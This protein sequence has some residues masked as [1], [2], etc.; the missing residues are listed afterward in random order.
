MNTLAIVIACGKEEEVSAGVE[1]AFLTLGNRPVLAHS[2]RTF[3]D[4]STIDGIIVAVSKERVE[5][6]LQVIKRFGYTKVCGIV[7][8]GTNRLSSLRT[9]FSKL[10]S[11]ASYIIVHEASRPFITEQAVGECVKATKRYGCAI[12][13]HKLPDVV[14]VAAKGLKPDKTIERNSAWSAQTPQAFKADVFE[15]IIHSKNKNMKLIDDES[16]FVKRPAEVHMVEAG[17]KNIKIRTSDDFAMAT[18]MFNANLC[19]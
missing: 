5:S 6:A 15:K 18:A 9:V 16:E 8:G 4:S 17:S 10:P 14:K 13:A 12:A 11:P 19:R 7:V 1:T 3:Q 2:L